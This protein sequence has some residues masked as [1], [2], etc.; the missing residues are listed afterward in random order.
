VWSLCKSWSWYWLHINVDYYFTHAISVSVCPLAYLDTKCQ[1]FAHALPY[2]LPVQIAWSSSDDRSIHYAFMVLCRMLR[3]Y[4]MEQMGQN[5]AQVTYWVCQVAALG[6]SLISTIA[7]LEYVY[8]RKIRNR[9]KRK[10]HAMVHKVYWLESGQWSSA[11]DSGHW[12]GELEKSC[13]MCSSVV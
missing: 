4:I 12:L 9:H 8:R 10:E 2:M 13:D 11:R 3:L 6:Q 1:N 5:Q 7:L